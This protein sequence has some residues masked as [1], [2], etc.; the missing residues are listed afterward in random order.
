MIWRSVPLLP[1]E[2]CISLPAYFLHK[3]IVIQI[4]HQHVLP[5]PDGILL[6]HPS[7][8]F[9]CVPRSPLVEQRFMQRP[10]MVHTRCLQCISQ[11]MVA[12]T[13]QQQQLNPALVA[14]QM[15]KD[16]IHCLWLL[17]L[18]TPINV[19]LG[20]WIAIK[21]RMEAHH[22]HRYHNGSDLA[23]N[24]FTPISI[25]HCGGMAVLN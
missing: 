20:D 14:G 19:S 17:I 1:R 6:R 7:L 22:G 21:P 13:G 5:L 3:L 10:Q 12:P 16:G 15:D 9:P 11:Q 24:T 23:A 2:D 18:Q 8:L 4:Y 25:M